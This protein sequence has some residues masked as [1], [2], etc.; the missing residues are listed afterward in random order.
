MRIRI[1]D[2]PDN[3]LRLQADVLS[4]AFPVI[5]EL[6]EAGECEFCEPI[7]L[8]LRAIRVREWIEV[9]GS[10]DTRVKLPC[11]RCLETFQLPLQ[12][13]FALTFI[14][15]LPEISDLRGEGAQLSAEDMGLILFNGKE[16][17]LTE[18][19]QE[20]LVLALP[21]RPLCKDNCRGLCPQCGANLNETCCTC[22]VPASD[23]RF[24]ILK[25]LLSEK[26]D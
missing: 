4:Q 18:A 21:F 16:I 25:D 20:Q 23:S 17:D 24:A 2:I 15:A 26:D 6:I 11:S 14:E 3:G 10:L 9:K 13:H 12:N 5:R 22:R 7:H 1:E 8:Q 19:I